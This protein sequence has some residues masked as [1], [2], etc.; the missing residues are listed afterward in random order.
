MDDEKKQEIR[1]RIESERQQRRRL[2]W[3][4]LQQRKLDK[5]RPILDKN[6]NKNE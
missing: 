3:I 4:D 2:Y 5:I 6:E 1:W